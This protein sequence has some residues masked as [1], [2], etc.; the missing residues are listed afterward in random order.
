MLIFWKES[1]F[2]SRYIMDGK[3]LIGIGMVRDLGVLYDYK[4]IFDL[5][6]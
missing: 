2:C 6:I 3:E 1:Y 4:M 5:Q